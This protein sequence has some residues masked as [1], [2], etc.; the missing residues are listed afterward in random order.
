M[1]GLSSSCDTALDNIVINEGAC[2]G[3]LFYPYCR[4]QR[5]TF[6]ITV[7]IIKKYIN[8]F[9]TGCIAG[10]DFDDQDICG[11][12]NE[13]SNDDIYGW[14]TWSGQTD[15]PDTGPDDDFSK[16][17]RESN[18]PPCD[19]DQDNNDFKDF[20]ISQHSLFSQTVSFQ[21]S[22]VI[23]VIGLQV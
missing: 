6:H 7:I 15:T 8:L 17:G 11:W 10:C 1:R 16:P 2:A 3:T 9:Y 20:P 21:C 18:I 5:Y 22:G 13:V 4:L 12:V 14:E 19:F 23:L